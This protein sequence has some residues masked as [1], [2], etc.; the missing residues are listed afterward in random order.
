MNIRMSELKMNEKWNE[1]GSNK[2]RK[3]AYIQEN[4]N[5]FI[6]STKDQSICGGVHVKVK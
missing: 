3:Q 6:D 1:K 5:Q 2:S 4:K